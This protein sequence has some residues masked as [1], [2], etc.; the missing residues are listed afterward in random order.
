MLDDNQLSKDYLP[1]YKGIVLFQHKKM[2]RVNTDTSLLGNYLKVKKGDCVLDIGTNNGALL[3]YANL[4]QPATLVGIDINESALKLAKINFDENSVKNYLLIHESIVSFKD[5]ELFD[6]I[7]SNPPY[8]NTLN[9]ELK[10]DNDN[11]KVARHEEYLTLDMLFEGVKRNLKIDGTFY[12]IHPA[13][14]FNEV[15]EKLNKYNLFIK[16]YC[17]VKDENKENDHV[18]LYSITKNKNEICIQKERLIIKR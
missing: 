10:N 1:G 17:P 18:I 6:V 7:V 4:Y 2:F 3:L 8:F 11:L 9:N 14:R 5:K 13:F 12:L 16:E 15:K